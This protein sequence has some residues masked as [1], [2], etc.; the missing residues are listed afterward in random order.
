VSRSRKR[1]ALATGVAVGAIVVVSFLM[2]GDETRPPV[3]DESLSFSRD[4]NALAFASDRAGNGQISAIYAGRTGEAPHRVTRSGRS[5]AFPALSPDG[6]KILVTRSQPDDT[7]SLG[8][9]TTLYV[10]AADGSGARRLTNRDDWAPTWSPDGKTIVFVRGQDDLGIVTNLYSIGVD[11]QDARLLLRHATDPAWSPDGTRI[12]FVSESRQRIAVLNRRTGKVATV[13]RAKSIASSPAWSPDGKRL[14]FDDVPDDARI[15]IPYGVC[16]A[17]LYAI[18][19][20][21]SGLRRLTR[22]KDTDGSP[23]WTPDG[24]IVFESDRDGAMRFF[25][26]NADGTRIRRFFPARYLDVRR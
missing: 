8:S 3:N 14:A 24:R 22:N 5:E 19:V 26:V 25:I 11:G 16:C 15:D 10:I 7:A 1:A 17:E 23:T 21:G 12:A 13:V 2:G 4:G 18:N 9:R 6:S 20:D